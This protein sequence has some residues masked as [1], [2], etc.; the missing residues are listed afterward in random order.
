M[1]GGPWDKPAPYIRWDSRIRAPV[2]NVLK[3]R[4]AADG[5]ATRY[6]LE[7]QSGGIMKR[8]GLA[9][10]LFGRSAPASPAPESYPLNVHVRSTYIVSGH[11]YRQLAMDAIINDEEIP[12]TRQ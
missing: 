3:V 2:V 4:L 5:M 1:A 8:V 11:D 6:L 7:R 9:A 10:L 12:F